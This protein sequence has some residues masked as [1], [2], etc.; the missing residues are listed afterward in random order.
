MFGDFVVRCD[1]CSCINATAKKQ[2]HLRD[3]LL[4]RIN[5]AS[6]W[7]QSVPRTLAVTSVREVSLNFDVSGNDQQ[8][9]SVTFG[10]KVRVMCNSGTDM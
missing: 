7:Q 1:R 5:A 8:K 9:S 2:R 3:S 4:K 10:V 6:K